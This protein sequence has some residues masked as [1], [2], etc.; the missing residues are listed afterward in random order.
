MW[1]PT[2][3][4]IIRFSSIGDIV[5]STPLVRV[6]RSR[7]PDMQMD[8]VVRKEYADLIR[9]NQNLNVTHEFD[10]STGFAGLRI[11]KKKLKEER[12]DLILDL[13]DSIRSRYLR[14]LLGVRRIEVLDKRLKE[15]TVLVRFKKNTYREIVP[16]ADRYIETVEEFGIENDGKGAELHIPDETLF[17]V[18]GRIAALRLNRFERVLGLCPFARHATKEWPT[19]RFSQVAS[20]FVRK[21]DGAV[22]IFGGSADGERGLPLIKELVNE[23]GEERVINFTGTLTLSE[24]AAA[25]QYCDVIVTNDT[26]L[27]HIA[28]AMQRSIVAM[29]GSTVREFGFFPSE[30]R[31][32]VL[33]RKGLYC[34]PCSHI[35]RE[36]CPEGHFRCMKEIESAGVYEAIGTLLGRKEVSG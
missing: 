2:K 29:F 7:F 4:L 18:S 23:H 34:R 11:L 32:I 13:H 5:L 24:T 27:M 28:D 19:D 10:A 33:E 21:F 14:S 15:R 16:V 30:N 31:S 8:Y 9:S 3:T 35:G 17:S 12:Y 22:M 25:M 6:L 20:G 1:T 36:Q 26:G